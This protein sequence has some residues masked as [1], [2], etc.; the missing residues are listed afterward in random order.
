[1]AS[2]ISPHS[3][4]QIPHCCTFRQ[5][6]VGLSNRRSQAVIPNLAL[7]NVLHIKTPQCHQLVP[8]AG[9]V[10]TIQSTHKQPSVGWSSGGARP[11]FQILLPST[12]CR[13]ATNKDQSKP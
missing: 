1:M 12:S 5:P 9:E 2:L 3:K 7:I 11:L 4:D 6:P 8:A 10:A 13:A